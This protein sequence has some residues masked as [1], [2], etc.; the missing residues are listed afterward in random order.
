MAEPHDLVNKY[1]FGVNLFAAS[2]PGALLF[3]QTEFTNFQISFLAGKYAIVP[4][5]LSVNLIN[6]LSDFAKKI[7]GVTDENPNPLQ[8]PNNHALTAEGTKINFGNNEETYSI[9]FDNTK[10]V[11]F[12]DALRKVFL[13]CIN[14][15]EQQFSAISKMSTL[16]NGQ[17]KRI[18]Y[19]LDLENESELINKAVNHLPINAQSHTKQYIVNNSEL[20]SCFFELTR[21]SMN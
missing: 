1:P 15:S 13:G 17:Q 21:I 16:L 14:P 9:E 12:I 10:L 7:S 8:L 11:L 5:Y 6:F 2:K 3:G 4:F 18:P 20:L 19:T